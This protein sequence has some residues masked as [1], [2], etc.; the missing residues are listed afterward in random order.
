MYC[1][2]PTSEEAARA[3]ELSEDEEVFISDDSAKYYNFTAASGQLV[4]HRR[5][6][7]GTFMTRE[8]TTSFAS[9]SKSFKDDVPLG[10]I[11][12][13]ANGDSVKSVASITIDDHSLRHGSYPRKRCSRCTRGKSLQIRSV[14]L[15]RE[16]TN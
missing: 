14:L 2:L 9:S 10:M 6:S 13:T 11:H 5:H 8:R 15:L 16:L 12:A 4:E 7:I 1:P 3:A